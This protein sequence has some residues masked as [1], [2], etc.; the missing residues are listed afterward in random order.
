MDAKQLSVSITRI[1]SNTA[2]KTTDNGG[3][4]Y[5]K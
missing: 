2:T 5:K 1:F 4:R 3:F